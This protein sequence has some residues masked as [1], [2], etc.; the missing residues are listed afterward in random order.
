MLSLIDTLSH[1][2]RAVIAGRSFLIDL[3]TVVTNLDHFIHLNKEARSDIE[4]W[5]VFSERWNGVLMM[6][7]PNNDSQASVSMTSDAS[8]RWGCGAFCSPHLFM[9]K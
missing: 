7:M 2:C 1:A 4:W 8:G 9:L 3:L 6:H 5:S